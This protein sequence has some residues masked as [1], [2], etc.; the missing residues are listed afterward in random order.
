MTA[1]NADMDGR[2]GHFMDDQYVHFIAAIIRSGL[3]QEGP[4]YVSTSGGRY[5]CEL[6]QLDP[7]ALIAQAARFNGELPRRASTASSR[8]EE[9]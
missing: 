8:Y 9:S 5:W 1:D 3:Q 4:A 7:E 6:G 2:I